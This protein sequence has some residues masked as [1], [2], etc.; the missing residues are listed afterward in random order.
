MKQT[1]SLL[2]LLALRTLT[3]GVALLQGDS[4]VKRLKAHRSTFYS[5]QFP[6]FI[7]DTQFKS[8]SDLAAEVYRLVCRTNFAAPGFALIRQT[9]VK[10]SLEQRQAMIELKEHLSLAHQARVG[11]ALNWFCLNR[12]D[13]EETTKAH[14]DGAPAQSLL[15]LGYEPTKVKSQIWVA[16]Y[17]AC[18]HQLG[19]SPVQFL[20]EFNPMYEKGR[21]HLAPYMMPV[22]EYDSNYY[23]ILVVNNSSTALNRAENH[24]QGL[25]HSADITGGNLNEKRI[26]NSTIVTPA[27]ISPENDEVV[28]PPENIERFLKGE[29]ITSKIY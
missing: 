28:V 5:A 13:Q 21:L 17:S 22:E 20:E 29:E 18:A 7:E 26:I 27:S 11:P 16:D 8:H 6:Y 2:D 3:V 9:T 10:S 14:R 24:W 15:I 19:L 25:L 23:Q 12:F 1:N 4:A